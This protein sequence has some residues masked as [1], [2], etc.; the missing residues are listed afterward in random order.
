M[1]KATPLLDFVLFDRND[2]RSARAN[3]S[4]LVY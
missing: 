1:I 2:Y 4:K 3:N